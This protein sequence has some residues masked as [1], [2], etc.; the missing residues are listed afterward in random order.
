[1][2]LFRSPSPCLGVGKRR[3]TGFCPPG[4]HFG[5]D[6]RSWRW[7]RSRSVSRSILTA[8]VTDPAPIL[9]GPVNA[10]FCG[11]RD[12]TA[13]A[14]P[15]SRGRVP[16]SG[17]GRGWLG[18]PGGGGDFTHDLRALRRTHCAV[19]HL[20]C[21]VHDR[22]TGGSADTGRPVTPGERHHPAPFP[23]SADRALR[24][25]MWPEAAGARLDGSGFVGRSAMFEITVSAARNGRP[26]TVP[27]AG[28]RGDRAVS[29]SAAG[30]WSTSGARAPAPDTRRRTRCG[31][32]GGGSPH[33]RG[34]RVGV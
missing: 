12:G 5:S 23:A 18:S 27:H 9:M 31:G 15:H 34:R 16:P 24:A 33:R 7:S 29:L 3:G 20:L 30:G 11:R 14:R 22:A 25:S 26:F 32:P 17:D 10:G 1:M 2:R 8:C 21:G 13:R 6:R 28:R 19:R 4:A